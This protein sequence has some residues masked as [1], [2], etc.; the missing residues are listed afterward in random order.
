MDISGGRILNFS[1]SVWKVRRGCIFC[2]VASYH[3]QISPVSW[4][5]I[6]H[7]VCCYVNVIQRKQTLSTTKLV[8]YKQK[9]IWRCLINFI[10]LSS[11][12]LCVGKKST[13]QSSNDFSNNTMYFSLQFNHLAFKMSHPSSTMQK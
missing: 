1:V 11:S 2:A 7:Q 8:P 3:E 4:I 9:V 12:V 10:I 13:T 6:Y 5:V